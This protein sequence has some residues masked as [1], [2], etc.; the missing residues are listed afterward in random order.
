MKGVDQVVSLS[1]HTGYKNFLEPYIEGKIKKLRRDLEDK[2]FETLEEVKAAQ[3]KL[4]AYMDV[5][6]FVDRRVEEKLNNRG[7]K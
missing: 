6:K 2:D 5:L 1:R 7:G 3:A 4:N